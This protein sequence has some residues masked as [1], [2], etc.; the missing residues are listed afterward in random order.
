MPVYDE[1]EARASQ[2]DNNTIFVIELSVGSAVTVGEGRSKKLAKHQ[3][4]R[5]MYEHLINVQRAMREEGVS[6]RPC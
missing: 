3:A 2:A 1:R 6:R 5:S 4:A